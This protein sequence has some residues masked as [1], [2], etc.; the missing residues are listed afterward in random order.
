MP[1]HLIQRKACGYAMLQFRFRIKTEEKTMAMTRHEL[2]R[3]ELEA[4]RAE[5]A[6]RAERIGA[7]LQEP[8]SADF[9][10]QASETEDDA[11]LEGQERVALR[12]IAA[13]D[14]AIAR[15]EAGSYGICAKC[16]E[17]IA[18][19][20]LEALPTAALCISCARGK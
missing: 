15:L 7:D 19:A 8:R 2:L 9:E 3:Q 13:I 20:R 18:E 6:E 4:R 5:L 11:A 12:E 10:E 1:R 17:E 16:G 14:A